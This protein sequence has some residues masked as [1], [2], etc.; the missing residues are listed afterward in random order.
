MTEADGQGLE[1]RVLVLAP[2]SKDAALTHSVLDRAGV[3]SLGCHDLNEI[4]DHLEAGA[5]ADFAPKKPSSRTT[6]TD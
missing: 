5:A 3:A 6:T 4:C 2:T 1:Q